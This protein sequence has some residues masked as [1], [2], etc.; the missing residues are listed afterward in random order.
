MNTPRYKRLF[1]AYAEL[2]RGES[3]VIFGGR[4]GAYRYLNMDQT[5]R[6]ALR[7]F[8][9]QVIP[10]LEAR[11]AAFLTAARG[12]SCLKGPVGWRTW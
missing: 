4:L 9:E 8:Q 3:N 2:A 12:T 5:V 7:A 1:A 6:S 11:H 10:F